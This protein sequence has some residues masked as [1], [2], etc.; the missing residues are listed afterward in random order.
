MKRKAE[1]QQLSTQ[2]LPINTNVGDVILLLSCR[3]NLE[4]CEHILVASEGLCVCFLMY[5]PVL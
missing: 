5:H 2:L 4:H 3:K 1:K